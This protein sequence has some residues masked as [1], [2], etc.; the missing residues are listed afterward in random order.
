MYFI[1]AV[2]ITI[3]RNCLVADIS[4]TAGIVLIA[5]LSSLT[6]ARIELREAMAINY[7]Y[8]SNYFEMRP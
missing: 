7:F 6:G 3:I 4:L 8:I 2:A 1:P 5:S